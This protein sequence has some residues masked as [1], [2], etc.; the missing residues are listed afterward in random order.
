MSDESITIVITRRVRP[1][2]EKAFERAVHD[3]I[4]RAIAFPG[5]LGAFLLHPHA[6]ADSSRGREYGAVLRF[7]SLDLWNAFRESPEYREFL[8]SIRPD[9]LEVPRT[10]AATGLEAWF[11]WT[12]TTLPPPR[13][14][15][16]IV[17]WVGVCLTVGVLGIL[18]GPQMSEWPPLARLLT[19]N[20]AVVAVL[21]WGVMPCLTR[22]T[23]GWLRPGQRAA[24]QSNAAD[25]RTHPGPDASS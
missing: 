14:K 17:T 15:M 21:T 25:R 20:A 23:H 8:E 19:M 18:L 3:W 11:R 5:H 2:R 16:A 12:G 10:E 22:W 6:T 13:W 24:R 4:P 1:G 9:L 7:R